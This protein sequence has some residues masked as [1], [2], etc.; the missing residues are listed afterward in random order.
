M[1]R[2]KNHF[3][4]PYNPEPWLGAV[5]PPRFIILAIFYLVYYNFF[6]S[7]ELARVVENWVAPGLLCTPAGG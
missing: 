4:I 5:R 6:D 3:V 2:C 7:C 1:V